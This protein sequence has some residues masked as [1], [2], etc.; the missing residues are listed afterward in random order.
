[1]SANVARSPNSTYLPCDP[2]GAINLTRS[3]D[4]LP[5]HYWDCGWQNARY[6]VNE[7]SAINVKS[8]R[9]LAIAMF[10]LFIGQAF[11]L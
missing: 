11:G 3:T 7:N 10:V 6:D 2:N 5:I 9:L 8:S 4:L 1:M